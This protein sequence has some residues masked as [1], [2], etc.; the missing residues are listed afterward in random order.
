MWYMD[1]LEFPLWLGTIYDI[2]LLYMGKI[3]SSLTLIDFCNV[4]II[5]ALF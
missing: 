1:T 3:D 5:S 4:N 2:K